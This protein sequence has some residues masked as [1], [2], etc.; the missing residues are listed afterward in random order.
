MREKDNMRQKGNMKQK[1]NM[2]ADELYDISM[3]LLRTV[4]SLDNDLKSIKNKKT[5]AW[6]KKELALE[7]RLREAEEI[8]KNAIAKLTPEEMQALGLKV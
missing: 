6:C 2:T 3:V 7:A 8:K 1:D 5:L 4:V